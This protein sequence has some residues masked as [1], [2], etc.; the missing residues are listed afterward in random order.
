MWIIF[1]SFGE[2]HEAGK[3]QNISWKYTTNHN[4]QRTLPCFSES[5]IQTGTESCPSW[6]FF[7]ES[8]K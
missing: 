7:I 2:F 1:W 8:V 3:F 4:H 6:T 5:S